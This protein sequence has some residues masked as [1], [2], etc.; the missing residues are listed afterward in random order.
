MNTNV[1][2]LTTYN[3]IHHPREDRNISVK[4]ENGKRSL[5][6]RELTNKTIIIGLNKYLDI[7]TD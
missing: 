2:K 7:T 4:G 5:I 6:Q 1:R 3:K